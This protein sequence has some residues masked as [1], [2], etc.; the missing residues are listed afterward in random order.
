MSRYRDLAGQAAQLRARDLVEEIFDG[1]TEEE[2]E[3]TS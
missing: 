3:L 2:Q 1:V